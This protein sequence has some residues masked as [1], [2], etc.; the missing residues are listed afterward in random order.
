MSRIGK[1]PI[2][3]PTGVKYTVNENGNSVLVEGPKGKVSALL[4]GGITLVQ[5]DGTLVVERQNDKQ[6]AFH[7]LARALVFN[8]VTGVTTGWS[9]EIDIVGI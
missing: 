2:N 6:A 8:A 3:L 5:K 4:P 7:G 9:K 1:K